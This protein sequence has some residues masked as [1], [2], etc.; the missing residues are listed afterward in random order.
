MTNETTRSRRSPLV[1]A[2]ATLAMT[3]GLLLSWGSTASAQVVPDVVVDLYATS[4]RVNLVDP[5]G[6]PNVDIW[7]YVDTPGA[8][9]TAPGGPTIRA[10]VGQTVQINLY[11]QLWRDPPTNTVAGPTTGLW[12]PDLAG[13]M[14][15]VGQIQDNGATFTSYTFAVTEP[16]TY[17]YEAPPI[18]DD[19]AGG[20]VGTQYQTAMGLNG[21]LVV[22]TAIVGEAYPGITYDV[23]QVMVLS[24]VDLQLNNRGNPATFDM[25]DFDPEF[26]LVNGQ[27]YT[28]F[29]PNAIAVD[30]GQTLLLRYVNTGADAHTMGVLGARQSLVAFG[31]D[32]LP[33]PRS[34]V[35]ERFGP[36]QSVDAL[37]EIPLGSDGQQ[38]LV[39]DTSMMLLSNTNGRTEGMMATIDI[40]DLGGGTGGGQGPLTSN[41]AYVSPTVT[42]TVSDVT[43]GGQNVA[44]AEYFLN[45]VGSPGTGA[46]MSAVDGLFDSP[47]EDVELTGVIITGLTNT[48]YV[49]GQDADG[50]WGPAASLTITGTDLEAPTTYNASLTPNP[51]DGVGDVTVEATGD[52]T[53]TGGSNITGGEAYINGDTGTLYSLTANNP[54]TIAALSGTIPATAFPVPGDYTISIRSIDAAGNI[55]TAVDVVLTVQPALPAVGQITANPNPN[56]GSKPFNSTIQAV[57]V[58]T[59]VSV[60]GGATVAGAEAFIDTVGA[61]GTGIDLVFADGWADSNTEVMYIDIPLTTVNQLTE[62]DH[63]IYIHGLSSTGTWGDATLAS[64]VLTIDKTS[65]TV[66]GITQV[67]PDPTRP[68]VVRFDVTFSEV[69]EGVTAANFTLVEGVGMTGSVIT[70]TAGIAATPTPPASIQPPRTMPEIGSTWRVTVQTGSVGGTVGLDLTST[71]GL[72]DLAGNGLPAGITGPV[73]TVS[74]FRFTTQGSNNALPP[75]VA[76][77][78]DDADVYAFDVPGTYSRLVD[79]IGDLGAPDQADI[80]AIDWHGPN[81][82]YFS[83]QATYSI[84]GLTLADEDVAHWDGTTVTMFFDGSAN[85]ITQG[86]ADIDAITVVGGDLYFSLLNTWNPVN[87]GTGGGDDS[88]IYLWDGTGISLAVDATALGVPGSADVNGLE[89]IG[90][91]DFFVSFNNNTGVA[92]TPVGTVEDEDIVHYSGAWS[93]YWDGSTKG[94]DAN[95]GQ[96]VDGIDVP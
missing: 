31:G 46:P 94:F 66:T 95:N 92:L 32:P 39:Y 17:L 87:V 50:N 18:L 67:D 43:T 56:N 71:A 93:M 69:V 96:D 33:L 13:P 79:G 59:T 21:V 55:G 90:P 65:P 28:R 29:H 85:G 91:S 25:R 30:P 10:T 26:F 9:L 37:V 48:I 8:T 73:Y 76:G 44:A 78:G 89:Y 12:L 81:D 62:G 47:T 70:G 1:A 58:Q 23:E 5:A 14:N 41:L 88:D 51:F 75:G 52:D 40:A 72:T 42:A 2:A 63:T 35:A 20:T 19:G 6:T 36:G 45:T 80:D 86:N 11:N 57:R 77:P 38:Y 15:I 49:R 83:V 68:G 61:D 24:E 7:G 4:N 3:I 64:T 82:V 84:G 16:G 60:T 34:V 53:A 22:D 54:A 27:A 74:P